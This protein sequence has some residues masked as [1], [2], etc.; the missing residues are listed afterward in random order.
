V[1]DLLLACSDN[2]QNVG[3]IE[4]GPQAI[5]PVGA[6]RKFNINGQLEDG[7]TKCTPQ[8]FSDCRRKVAVFTGVTYEYVKPFFRQL[9]L[10]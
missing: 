2:E 10:L 9:T 5:A 7:G 8:L 1:A 3:R 4:I 6:K